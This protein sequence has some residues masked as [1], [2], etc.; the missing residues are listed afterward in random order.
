MRDSEGDHVMKTMLT[1]A[2]ALSLLG[3]AAASAQPWEGRDHRG[4]RYEHN[5]RGRGSD[6]RYERRDRGDD[7]RDDRRADRRYDGRDYRAGAGYR[8]Y[9]PPAPGRWEQRRWARGQRLPGDYRGYYPVD[10][11][12]YHLRR[13]PSGYHWVRVDDDYVLAAIATGLILDVINNGY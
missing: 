13:P 8:N 9:R 1:A 3:A 6:N 5:D 4:D 12:A 11:R 7:R 2:L 10:Y